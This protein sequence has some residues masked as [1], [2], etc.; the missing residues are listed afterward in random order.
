MSTYTYPGVYIEELPSGQHTITGAATSIAA[1]IGWTNQGPV[2][3]AVMVESWAEYEAMF[4]GLIPGI[5]LGYAVYQFFLNGGSQ[6]YIVR[7]CVMLPSGP[8]VAVAA[9]ATINGLQVAAA[10]PGSWGNNIAIAISNVSSVANTFNLQVFE[11]NANGTLSLVESYSNLSISATSPQYAVT[12][13][14]SQSNYIA[15][16]TTPPPP[17]SPPAS[18]TLPTATAYYTIA[19]SATGSVTPG[20][21][22]TQAATGATAT[23]V[24]VGTSGTMLITGLVGGPA[25]ATAWTGAATFTPS[26]GAVPIQSTA[27]IPGRVTSGTFSA[28][29]TVTQSQSGG[30]ATAYLIGG[31][32]A[33]TSGIVT[34]GY[35]LVAGLAGSAPNSFNTW[36]D[37][38]GAV[39]TPSGSPLPTSAIPLGT[40]STPGVTDPPL[41][42]TDPASP[43]VQL[44]LGPTSSSE[45]MTGY[46]L[47]AN[48]TPMFNLLC[49]PGHVDANTIGQLQ[50]FCAINR[51]FL[52]V[53]SPY[54]QNLSTANVNS[55]A[56]SSGPVDGGSNPLTNGQYTSNAAFYFP[57]ISASDPIS[58]Q[59]ALFP[60]GGFVA[61]IYAST[62]A[63]RGVWKAPAGIDAGLTG[64]VGLQYV[65]SD[66]QNGGLNPIAV[67]CVRQFP[68]FGN[69]VWGARTMAGADAVG[70]QWKY[71]PIRRL[72]LFIESSLYAGTQWAVFEPNSEPLWG[73]VRLSIGTFMQGLFLQ[74]AFAGTTPQQAYFVKCDDENNTD[75]TT[76]LGI[77]NVT[78]GFAPLYP[79]EFV[80]IQIQQMMSQS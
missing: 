18:L 23:L 10:N 35:L 69:V 30:S 66:Q 41:Q 57:W 5:Y 67:N 4:G 74:G 9:Q 73:Q 47:L 62:D 19:G 31:S 12:V 51:A 77:L 13:V 34:S 15:I 46:Q 2:G 68:S 17:I 70:S 61:G 7:L 76:A 75:A 14:N 78:V 32:A 72:A 16:T 64:S 42:A 20:S 50:E 65:M 3:E 36:S 56:N 63:S 48:V 80:V 71:V 40:S 53:D 28:S 55:M 39:F 49:V 52:I 33:S 79:A 11:L 25:N 59:S 43:F 24:S 58:G 22:V 60:P 38:G 54:V 37:S 45:P 1:F 44:L 26:S 29:E 21:G 27:L 6:A 8:G